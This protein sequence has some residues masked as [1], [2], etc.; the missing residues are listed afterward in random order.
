MNIDHHVY[1]IAPY[2]PQELLQVT[3]STAAKAYF[4]LLQRTAFLGYFDFIYCMPNAWLSVPFTFLGHYD[5]LV[6]L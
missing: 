1:F 2:T 3:L 4:L 5:P 6:R